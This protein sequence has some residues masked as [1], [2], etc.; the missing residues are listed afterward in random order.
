VLNCRQKTL[1]PGKIVASFC[2]GNRQAFDYVDNNPRFEFRPTEFTN[3]P[4]QIARNRKMVSISS[5][6]EVDLT[7]QVCA[8]S[9]GDRFYSGFGGQTDFIRGAARSEGGKPIIAMPS[10]TS[11]GKTSRIVTRL[12]PG[13][14]VV[15]TRAD[16]HYVVTEYGVAQLHGKTV[17]ERTLALI[18]IAHPRFR[19]DLMREARER[20]LVHPNQIA[21]PPGLQPYP[22]KYEATGTFKDDLR[23]QF[24][25]VQ[26]TDESLLKELFYSHSEQTILHRYFAHIRHLPHEQVQKFVTMDY[27]NNFALVGLIPH[28]G[29]ERMI[30]VGR[31]FRNTASNDAEV[32]FTVH[33][34]FQGQGIGTFLLRSLVRIAR[35]NG[36]VAFTADV[37]PDNRSMLS[38]FHSVAE[39]IE[40]KLEVGVIHIRFELAGL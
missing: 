1:L 6:I 36:I 10:V 40:A 17:R 13:A 38:V 28:E 5:A 11:D 30:C 22:K 12:K 39:K 15:T 19:D 7:G 26:P 16:V 3:D 37:L 20:K 25:P 33:D 23:V 18:S 35:E 9:I 8:D 2:F 24:R 14:G 29:R 4:F 32:A 27:R 21:L 34:D 31:Y